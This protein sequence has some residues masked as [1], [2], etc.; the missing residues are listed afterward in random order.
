MN[1]ATKRAFAREAKRYPGLEELC[2][3]LK[4][5]KPPKTPSAARKLLQR[6]GIIDRHGNLTPFYR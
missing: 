2:A 6:A 1:A 5:Q 4:R 3:R